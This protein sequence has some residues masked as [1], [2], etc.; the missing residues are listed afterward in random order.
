MLNIYEYRNTQYLKKQ[1]HMSL[2]LHFSSPTYFSFFFCVYTYLCLWNCEYVCMWQLQCNLR[3][4]CISYFLV[5][6]LHSY[7]L[8]FLIINSL[9]SLPVSRLWILFWNQASVTRVVNVTIRL[10]WLESGGI[11]GNVTP[12]RND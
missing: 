9:S 2:S 3:H 10:E 7:F 1:A 12:E 8:P 4:S 11:S 6:L 5:T